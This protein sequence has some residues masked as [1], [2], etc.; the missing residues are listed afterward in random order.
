MPEDSPKKPWNEE[1][2]DSPEMEEDYW[3]TTHQYWESIRL[4]QPDDDGE[5]YIVLDRG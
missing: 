1:W 3:F 5:L 4:G 2:F